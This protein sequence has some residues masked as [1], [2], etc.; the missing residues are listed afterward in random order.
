M[1]LSGDGRGA[2][3]LYL[4]HLSR[5]RGLLYTH[6]LLQVHVQTLQFENPLLGPKEIRVESA[7][8]IFFT[9][10]GALSSST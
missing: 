5:H 10:T 4:R 2:W 3:Y 7:T 8:L 6:P 9:Y 1:L